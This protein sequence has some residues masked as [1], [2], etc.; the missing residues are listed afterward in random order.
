MPHQ[1]VSSRPTQVNPSVVYEG[2]EAALSQSRSDAD[3]GNAVDEVA[4]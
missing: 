3:N 1:R 2:I 4:H